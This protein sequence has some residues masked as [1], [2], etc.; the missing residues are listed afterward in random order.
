LSTPRKVRA[1]GGV[2]VRTIDGEVHLLLIHRRGA[3]DLPKGKAK[4]GESIRDCARREV[5]EELGMDDARIVADLGTTRHGYVEG[6]RAI[7]KTTTW[8][9][10]RTEADR[11]TPQT[12]EGIEAVK[13]VP[14]EEAESLLSFDTLRDLVAR[15]RAHFREAKA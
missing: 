1:G 14:L 6:G 9:L 5:C 7:E 13:W 10:M 4:K 3:W 12:S 8:F 2:L 11:F 15:H